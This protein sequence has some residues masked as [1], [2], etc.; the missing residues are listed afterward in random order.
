MTSR[1]DE[2]I[3]LRKVSLSY[4]EI[5][6]RLDISRERARQ[7]IK[8]RPTSQK[9]DKLML[10]TSGVAQLLGVHPN[11]VRHWSEKGILKTYRIGPRSDRRFRKEDMDDFLNAGEN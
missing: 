11:T 8:G 7:I 3:K 5:G 10:T 1:R 9:S 6:R 2:V 4:A